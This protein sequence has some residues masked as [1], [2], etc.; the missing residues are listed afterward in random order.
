MKAM[1]PELLPFDESAF[2]QGPRPRL[3]GLVVTWTQ[4]KRMHR[5]LFGQPMPTHMSIA[6]WLA[7]RDAKSNRIPIE[8]LLTLRLHF[9]KPVVEALEITDDFLVDLISRWLIVQEGVLIAKV[10]LG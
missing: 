2:L 10:L 7:I 3:D 6:S 4:A 9:G 5:L 8:D 1:T